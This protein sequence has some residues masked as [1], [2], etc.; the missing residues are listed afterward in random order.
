MGLF[1]NFLRLRLVYKTSTGREIMYGSDLQISSLVKQ[2]ILTK[3]LI[4]DERRSMR[5]EVLQI[6]M[7][8]HALVCL[9]ISM[10]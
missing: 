6:V 8:L 1:G 4:E 10:N 3:K 9:N 7:A 2:R 5:F